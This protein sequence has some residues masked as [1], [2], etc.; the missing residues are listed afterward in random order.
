MLL[1]IRDDNP[2]RRFPIVTVALI[3]INIAI[4]IYTL[5]LPDQQALIEFYNRYALFPK[6]IATGHP[7][8]PNE[9]QPVYLSL[10]TSM[11]LHDSPLPL[12]IGFNMLFLWIFGNNVEDM[13]GRFKYI[14]FYL[15]AGIAG[16]LL[17][18]AIDPNSTVPNIGASG[19]ISGVLAS[20]LI[21]FP[22]ARVLTVIPIIFFFT[23]VRIPAIVV[24]G[25]WFLLQ[26]FSAFFGVGGATSGGV[27]YF[28]HIGGF[29]A[30]LLLTLLVPRHKHRLP[31]Q[32]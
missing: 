14:I 8:A 6:A 2:T 32:F 19:A 11:F 23:V 13:F 29:V 1:P 24:I 4:Y 16:S 27:A 17:Q 30:G 25:F 26:V 22:S 31:Q 21:L 15:L 18:I 3:A 10:F 5:T 9:I 12:H 28:A 20:Y 7:V